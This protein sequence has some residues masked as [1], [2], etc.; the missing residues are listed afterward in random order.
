MVTARFPR[1]TSPSVLNALR[2]AIA[3]LVPMVVVN[4]PARV[5]M[6][7]SPADLNPAA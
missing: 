6:T 4:V 1:L 5:V 7:T 2:V 3:R